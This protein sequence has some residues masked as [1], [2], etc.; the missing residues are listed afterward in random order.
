[1]PIR[2]GLITTLNHNLGDDFIREG[3]KLVL[4]QVLNRTQIEYVEVD[5]HKPLS[6]LPVWHPLQV[7]RLA[8][9]LPRGAQT[10]KR[11]AE[12]LFSG[13]AP[14]RFDGCGL[15][16][17]CGAPVLWPNCHTA[18]WAA[19]IWNGVVRRLHR[20]VPVL[21]LAGGA[22]YPCEQVPET[23]T[24]AADV[25]FLR[26]IVGYCRLTTVRDH[27]AK[28]LLCS[29]GIDSPLIPCSAFLV[30]GDR[31]A[32]RERTGPILISYMYGGGHYDWNQHIDAEGW[33]KTVLELIARLRRRHEIA[34]LC[35]NERER[36]LAGRL[37][38]SLPCLLPKT[39]KEFVDVVSTAKTA[40]CNRMHASVALA[41]LGI[42][43]VAVCTD[44]RLDMVKQLGLPC[45]YVKEATTDV[46]E[47]NIENLLLRS[48][49]ERTRLAEL[50]T[51]VK[52]RYVAVVSAALDGSA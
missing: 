33:E 22:C 29:I 12:L 8:D 11:P 40:V 27:L 7:N 50:K 1:M 39:A 4:E 17:Q 46:L 31:L 6:I 19:P 26:A 42:P 47:S 44:T 32:P 49:D 20:K 18:E 3:L 25:R 30:A 2:V 38:P 34:F 45:F 43:S 16:V 13:L 37:D 14:S 21:N 51:C 36:Q 15:I 9:F 52:A 35:H 24:D 5:K 10:A 41:S 23:L 48:S 28:T